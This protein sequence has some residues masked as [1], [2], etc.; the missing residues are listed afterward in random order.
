MV[1]RPRRNR[2]NAA[3]RAMVEETHLSADHL[4]YPLFLV[5]G[6]GIKDEIPSLPKNY[7]WSVDLLQNEIESSLR[8]GLNKFVLFPAVAEHLK[9]TIA[10]YSYA[11]DNFYLKAIRTIKESFPE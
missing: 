1:I 10:S 6:L 3:I 5:D 2:K 11:E 7:R 4:I 9:D 8:L